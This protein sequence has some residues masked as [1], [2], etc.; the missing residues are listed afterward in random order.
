ENVRLNIGTMTNLGVVE[1]VTKEIMRIK[2]KRPAV[3]LRG[4]RVALSRIVADR[5]RLAGS[6]I[7]I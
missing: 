5:W 6:G 1:E 2:L 4:D 7:I 3:T